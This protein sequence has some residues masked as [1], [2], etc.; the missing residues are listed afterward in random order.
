[1]GGFFFYDL[2]TGHSCN[3]A[4]LPNVLGRT[5]MDAKIWACPNMGN[6]KTW[7]PIFFLPKSWQV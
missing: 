4:R 5:W 1:M 7:E 6:T 2:A 3:P